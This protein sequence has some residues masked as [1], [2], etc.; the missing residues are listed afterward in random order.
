MFRVV[1]G[2]IWGGGAALNEDDKF[3]MIKK[4]M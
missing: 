3:I 4:R 2:K 1:L